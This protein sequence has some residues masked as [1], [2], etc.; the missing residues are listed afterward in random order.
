[1]TLKRKYINRTTSHSLG[2]L[3]LKKKE[4]RKTSDSKDMEKL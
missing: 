3:L 2:R 1:M 4:Q